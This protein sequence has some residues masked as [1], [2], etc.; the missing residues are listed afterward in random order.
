MTGKE[1]INIS[2]WLFAIFLSPDSLD[3]AY[4]P[5]LEILM[6]VPTE[7]GAHFSGGLSSSESSLFAAGGPVLLFNSGSLFT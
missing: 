7:V 5:L 6:C 4:L 3:Q 1:F 2:E